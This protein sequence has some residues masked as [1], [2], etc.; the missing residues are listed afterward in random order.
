MNDGPQNESS[1][2]D[3]VEPLVE[4]PG[5]VELRLGL[6]H[7]RFE[8]TIQ[9]G[10]EHDGKRGE[11]EVVAR[12]VGVVKQWLAREAVEEGEPEEREGKRN[13][14]VDEIANHGA[15]PVV[16]P[17]PVDEEK[18]LQEAKPREGIVGRQHGLLPL[19]APDADTNVRGVDHGDIVGAVADR[20]GDLAGH[21]VL[22][23]ESYLSLLRGR[24]STANDRF[25][26]YSDV[27]KRWTNR[28][29]HA[30]PEAG[31]VDD[32]RVPPLL[33]LGGERVN[34]PQ[35]DLY[36]LHQQALLEPRL[37]GAEVHGDGVLARCGLCYPGHGGGHGRKD[38]GG[39]RE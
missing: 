33:G 37:G 12:L 22:D 36:P 23:Q 29:L 5:A 14:L 8:V 9:N 39:P 1:E 6:D 26:P 25:A 13:V 32:E 34:Q 17:S 20:K 4:V 16:A 18:P 2:T 30:R 19:L 28:R 10:K 21:V 27:E 3:A 38:L 24:D 15:D 7:P 35:L 31:P 11:E